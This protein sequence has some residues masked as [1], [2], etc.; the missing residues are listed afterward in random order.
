MCCTTLQNP[1]IK[2][3]TEILGVHFKNVPRAPDVDLAV[4]LSTRPG[5]LH[6]TVLPQELTRYLGQFGVHFEG[7][8]EGGAVP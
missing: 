5:P 1:D 4:C 8:F 7:H 3:R 2:G 6:Q